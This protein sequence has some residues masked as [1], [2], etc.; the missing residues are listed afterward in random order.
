MEP[1][2]PAPHAVMPGVVDAVPSAPL[3]TEIDIDRPA[4]AL[5]LVRWS[6]YVLVLGC[7]QGALALLP[8]LAVAFVNAQ[9]IELAVTVPIVAA[10][11]FA[12]YT[13]WRHVGVID[14]RV[15]RTYL[16]VFPLLAALAAFLGLA[17]AATWMSQDGNPFDH[18]R[19]FMTVA[20]LLYFAG[21]AIPG[22]VCVRKLR[23]SRI[24]P[25]GARLD[26][27]LERLNARGGTS[28]LEVA[29]LRRPASG[30]GLTLGA[31]GAALLLINA[32]LPVPDDARTASNMFRLNQQ[33]NALGFFLV[34]R[35]RRHF[36]VSADALLAVDKRPPVLFL[37]SFADD[38]RPK[39]ASSERALVD[40]SLETRLAN[41]FHHFGP[42]IAIGSPQDALPQ[43]G[44]ARVLLPDDQWQSRVLDWMRAAGVI[45]MYSGT[46]EWVNW[47][48]RKVIESGRATSLILMFPEIKG[49]RGS[50]RKQDIATRVAQI[51]DVFSGSPWTEELTA[52]NDFAGLRA[53]LFRADGS[54]VMIKSRT[55][56]RDAYHLAALLAHQQLLDSASATSPATVNDNPTPL[57]RR[58][59]VGGAV[60]VVTSIAALFVIGATVTGHG[61]R[62]AFKQGE[63][64]YT[65]PVTE[66]A[67][68]AV[69]EYL[70][71]QDYFSDERKAS[72]Q[73]ALEDGIY[74]LRFVVKPGFADDSVILFHFGRIGHSISHEVLSGQPTEVALVDEQLKPIK[75]VP[76]TSSLTFGKSELY[77]TPPVSADLASAVGA[78]LSRV[79]LFTPDNEVSVHIARE[80]D[81]YQL[82][83][84]VNES[85]AE[86]AEIVD[87]FKQ[88]AGI[89]A[90]Q[91]LG[92]EPVI[93]HLCD[94]EF[95]TLTQARV[96][97]QSVRRIP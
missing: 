32:F 55:R 17:T 36:Q 2:I 71:Q 78:Q 29:G 91:A 80:H 84:V 75:V 31:L 14:P 43:P 49:W 96:E 82:R 30:R 53:M 3:I 11:T 34:V 26:V 56:S 1:A 12:A 52:F 37:R 90:V 60:A 89:V 92:G 10:F 27:L 9:W 13:G 65:D 28:G 4:R 7:G 97:A 88:I 79:K 24:A 33:L 23:R 95:R 69:G 77:Y 87:A 93:V 18:P 76:L 83:F 86:D 41:H 46:T 59:A 47:E 38:E 58:V 72:V 50:R 45:I 73:L 35:A 67:A 44:A 70:V 39:Y 61:T 25:M 64:Y 5:A 42:F 94:G 8:D 66:A 54:M 81:L 16:L 62:L 74:R 57:W 19:S 22:Y 21:F 68:R 15:W 51:R 85:R 63:L 40:F 6:D 20:G 48:L